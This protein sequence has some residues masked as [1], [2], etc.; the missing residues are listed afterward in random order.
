MPKTFT[1][2]GMKTPVGLPSMF[3]LEVSGKKYC[4]KPVLMADWPEL[5]PKTPNGQLPFM[6][7]PDGSAICESGA[8]GRAIAGAAG[9]LG[10]GKDYIVSEMLCGITYDL[11]KKAMDLA[12]SVFTADKFD[13]TKKQKY[14]AEKA[15]VVEFVE[16]KYDKFLLPSGDRFTKS[17]L[18]FGEIDLF[19][20]MYCHANGA[21]P[22][23]AK[24]KLA[25]FYQRMSEVPGIKKV[26]NGESQFGELATYLIPVP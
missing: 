21:Y 18:S 3:C 20:K 16:T 22:D 1:Y 10:S 9:L 8:C 26:I 2:F 15:G 12:P 7:M 25:K 14:Q 6:E 23:I 13:Y 5:K 11:N 24:G 19:S 4:G 17:G